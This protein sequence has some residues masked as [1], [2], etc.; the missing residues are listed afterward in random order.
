MI[1]MPDQ[2]YDDVLS[3]CG[4]FAY[5]AQFG[6]F[7][8]KDLTSDAIDPK[9]VDIFTEF[10]RLTMH[11]QIA[12]FHVM[13]GRLKA[14]EETFITH[15]KAWTE[16]VRKIQEVISTDTQPGQN[17][18]PMDEINTYYVVKVISNDRAVTGKVYIK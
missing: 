1:E 10:G 5:K 16:Q 11:Y 4:S 7:P 6:D 13:K 14:E 8:K 3:I 18:I 12:L 9:M 15:Q 2:F 17:V